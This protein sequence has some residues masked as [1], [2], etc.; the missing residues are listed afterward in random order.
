MA[1]SCASDSREAEVARTATGATTSIAPSVDFLVVARSGFVP[2][3]LPPQLEQLPQREH[4]QAAEHEAGFQA[5][6]QAAAQS[7]QPAL[8]ASIALLQALEQVDHPQRPLLHVP[9]GDR[10]RSPNR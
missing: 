4:D 8:K 5:D 7:V 1:D 10:G 6:D 3:P 2:T 9:P